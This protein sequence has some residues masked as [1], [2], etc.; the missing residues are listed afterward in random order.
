MLSQKCGGDVG[1][2]G[3]HG[4]QGPFTTMGEELGKGGQDKQG[5]RVLWLILQAE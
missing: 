4:S 2:A 3:V 1:L 5:Q